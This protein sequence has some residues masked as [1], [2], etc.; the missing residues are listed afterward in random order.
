MLGQLK[1]WQVERAQDR[2]RYRRNCLNMK[3]KR[4]DEM[5]RICTALWE[6]GEWPED[7]IN[8]IFVLI[9]KKEDLTQCKNYRT[10]ALVAHASKFMLK[11]ILERIREKTEPEINEQAGFRRGGTCDQIINLRILMQKLNEHQQ[12]LFMCFIDF[13]KAFDNISH[14]QLWVAMT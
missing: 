10:I 11:I 4:H 5:H 9:P 6:T 13:T 1:K 2:T 8:S 7:W 14:E 12:P 3:E